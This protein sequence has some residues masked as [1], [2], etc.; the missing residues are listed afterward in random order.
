MGV[1]TR[2]YTCF[3]L[4]DFGFICCIFSDVNH[5]R[6]I[7]A[8]DG[9][10]IRGILPLKILDY[11]NQ[12]LTTFEG[13]HTL[14][15]LTDMVAGTSTGALISAA[16][17]AEHSPG[18]PRFTPSDLLGL[19]AQR[20][21]Q[22]FSK[23]RPVNSSPLK[24]VL[25]SSFG[26]MTLSDLKKH[27][28]F[29]SYDELGQEPFVF[30]DRMSKYRDIRL[31]KALLASSAVQPHF[32]PV[33]LN[34]KLLSDG[35]VTAKN[36]AALAYHFAKAYFPDDL[37]VLLSFGTGALPESAHDSIEHKVLET[38]HHLLD[39]ALNNWQLMYY[40]FEPGLYGASIDMDDT[41]ESNIQALISAGDKYL[42][43]T[44]LGIDTVISKLMRLKGQL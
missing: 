2:K 42:D 27:F 32:S 12:R 5:L 11:I 9:G 14:H 39:E 25:E 13:N 38:H 22:I 29:V 36:P 1:Q 43:K 33:E 31:S 37:I 20:G 18:V 15:S 44:H 17:I 23:N 8:I 28:L 35:V 24:I 19:Y 6:L 40:R 30:S 34:G 7:L 26:E 21:P 4:L 41:S 16:I 10:G 3:F